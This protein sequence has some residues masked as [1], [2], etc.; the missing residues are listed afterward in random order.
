MEIGAIGILICGSIG[1][2][3]F[4]TVFAKRATI[5]TLKAQN[6]KKDA[7]IADLNRV[8]Y[9]TVPERVKTAE[10]ETARLKARI[11]QTALWSYE[12]GPHVQVDEDACC[13]VCGAAASVA[14]NTPLEE[15][16]EK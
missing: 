14:T 9:S 5:S 15:T 8:I 11:K 7:E 1:W 4:F 10:A 16:N 13:A 3:V 2:F 12:C 6:A